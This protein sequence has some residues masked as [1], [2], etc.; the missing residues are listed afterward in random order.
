L[1]TNGD[2]TQLTYTVWYAQDTPSAE[3]IF[4]RDDVTN[5]GY[6]TEPHLGLITGTRYQ[7]KVMATNSVGD[8]PESNIVL[9]YQANVPGTP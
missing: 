6:T 1:S 8:S 4:I 3:F 2:D 7:F 5:T 9:I